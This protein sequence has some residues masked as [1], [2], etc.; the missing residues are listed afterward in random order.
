MS[1]DA[2]NPPETATPGVDRFAHFVVQRLEDGQ[3]DC[4]G[5]GGMGVT[6]RARDTQLD[7]LVALK[8]ISPQFLDDAEVRSRFGREA[9]AAA[10]LQHPN[11]ASVLFQGVEGAS[12]FYAMELV[13]G[14]TL[15]SYIKRIGALAPVY[16]LKIAHQIALALGAAWKENV[17]HRDLKPG[18]VM[19]T[20]YDDR[21]EPHAKVI[22]FGLAKVLSETGVSYVTGGFV[23]TA[24]FASP[25]QCAE[26]PMLDIRSDLYSLG[27]TLWFMLAGRPPFSG[28]MLTIIQ[29]Q[30]NEPPPFEQLGEVP[31]PLRELLERLLAKSPDDRPATPAE[32]AREIEATL[33][34][35]SRDERS[36]D[37]LEIA[38]ART[39]ARPIS[40][41]VATAPRAPE[42]RTPLLLAASVA[43]AVIATGAALYFAGKSS[44]PRSAVPAA[45]VASPAQPGAPAP[46]ASSAFVNSLGMKFLPVPNT[47]VRM[48]VWET[49]VRDFAAFVKAAGY[50]HADKPNGDGRTWRQ[51][52]WAQEA[53]HPVVFVTVEDAQAFC[54][55]LTAAERGAGLI[56]R[57]ESYQVPRRPD[58]DAATGFRAPPR[59]GERTPD[60]MPPFAGQF[61]GGPPPGEPGRPGEAPRFAEGP[62]PPEGRPPGD[63][64]EAPGGIQPGNPGPPFLWG[65]HT[66]P[67]P[68]GAG[69]FGDRSTAKMTQ[70]P[71]IAGYDDGFVRT[72]P[73]GRFATGTLG[74]FDLA[75]NVWELILDGDPSGPQPFMLGGSWQSASPA[76]LRAHTIVPVAPGQRRPDVGFRVVLA[77]E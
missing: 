36:F 15:E 7:R 33:D 42:K 43:L 10:K 66:W 76:D 18:N 59:A 46:T 1:Q 6:Y 60:G 45:A 73:V 26:D 11:I 38:P 64:P 35:L 77:G 25:E 57:R 19:L 34:L 30:A 14:E 47:N 17:L 56:G 44:A 51:P 9:R 70:S 2:P 54:R 69:N 12:C 32:A 39:V 21:G 29:A 31:E 41:R 28:S 58:W 55:W 49:R 16:A 27:A 74:F 68:P 52:G 23:G 20:S 67:P 48:C 37:P 71:T 5:R 4:I 22:D 62:R 75:G 40:R 72:S 61:P 53:D 3:L 50:P 8:V 24:E 13:V 63:A 65:S